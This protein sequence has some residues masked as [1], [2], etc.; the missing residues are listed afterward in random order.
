MEKGTHTLLELP[1]R[2]P[3]T[4]WGRQN[5]GAPGY[6]GHGGEGPLGLRRGS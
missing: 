5:V 2:P 1:V 3:L 6:P 4:S